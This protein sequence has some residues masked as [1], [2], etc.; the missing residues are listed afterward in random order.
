MVFSEGDVSW[1]ASNI[2]PKTTS[3]NWAWRPSKP[4]ASASRAKPSASRP[5]PN[6]PTISRPDRRAG[7]CPRATFLDLSVM[8]EPYQLAEA[9][10][11]CVID[12]RAVF[13]DARRD[14]YFRLGAQLEPV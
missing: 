4:V 14:R 2:S 3:S 10:S 11:F 12:D 8:V 13:L 1:N 9:V 7:A 5:A 6:F